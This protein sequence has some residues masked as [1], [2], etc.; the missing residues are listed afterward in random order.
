MGRDQLW[1][2]ALLCTERA[3][4]SG[5]LVPLATTLENLPGEDATT[6]ELRHLAGATPKH[7]REAGPKPNPFRPWDQRLEVD[8]IGDE[9]RSDSEQVSC[10]DRS[11]VV[12]Y[13]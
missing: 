9:P 3:L 11:Y 2:R 5:A 6:F 8:Q 7:L 4:Q 1:E 13:P 10:S 12:N